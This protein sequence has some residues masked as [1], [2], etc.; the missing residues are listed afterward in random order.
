MESAPWPL[1]E[2][3]VCGPLEALSQYGKLNPDY[4]LRGL[5]LTI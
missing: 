2:S 4:N 5:N 3:L 1:P